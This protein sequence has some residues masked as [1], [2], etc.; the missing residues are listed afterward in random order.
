MAPPGCI[1][2][3]C[4]LPRAF[5]AFGLA[6]AILVLVVAPATAQQP[7]ESDDPVVTSFIRNVTRVEHWS[8]FEPPEGG[9]D[10]TYS[11]FGN[12]AT[13]GVRV[14]SRRLVVQG[15]LQY[16]QM[17]GLP[18]RSI[19]PGP[20]GPGPIFYVSAENS[21]AYQLYFKTLSLRLKNI[22]PRL[23][24]EIGRMTYE[25]GENTP[26]AGRLIGNAEWSMFERAFD[27]VRLDYQGLAWRIHGSFVMPTQG[28]FEE[29]ASP[30][31]GLVKV[32]TASAS[33]GGF[34]M[35]A[36]NYRDTR[37]I[38]ARPDNTGARASRVD[39][40]LQTVGGA[41]T[42]TFAGLDVQLWGALQRGHWYGDEHRARS[43]SAEAGYRW[44]RVRAEPA[45]SAG[46]L[47]A[48]GDDD[49]ND[50][51]HGTFFPMLP[52]TAPPVLAGTY[53]QMNISD[54]YVRGGATP[55]P[56]LSVS[57][58]LHRLSLASRQNRWYSGTGATAF[59]GTYFG[60]SSRA[61]TLA[62]GLGTFMQ[63]SIESSFTPNWRVSATTGLIRGGAVVR[64]QFAGRSLVVF[65]LEN[66]LS[67]P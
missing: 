32:T 28:A 61:S 6:A 49:P 62:T 45:L 31:I 19:G 47:H 13:L 42:R 25:S 27:G 12:R 55:H 5:P 40:T 56:R 37:A 7:E 18:R 38:A 59:A 65:V 23:S 11:L 20:L 30:T 60:Y 58:E 9:G 41:L 34:E 67:F 15:S 1:G 51:T 44:T 48:S 53:A 63:L 17:I 43:G 29:S 35:F 14:V 10:P 33:R 26:F 66:T 21:R 64:R 39:V 4:R 46:L 50:V 2:L 24:I 54:V 8:F 22:M 3:S 52:T 16:A 36:H 57:A